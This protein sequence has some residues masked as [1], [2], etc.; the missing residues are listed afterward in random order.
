VAATLSHC[1]NKCAEVAGEI[2]EY[3]CAEARRNL[4][5]ALADA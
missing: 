4:T 3:S 2:C 1:S 5:L